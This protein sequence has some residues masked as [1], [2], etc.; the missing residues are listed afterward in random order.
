[1]RKLFAIVHGVESNLRK[2]HPYPIKAPSKN[3]Y[4][5]TYIF[6]Y[7]L[8]VVYL[9]LDWIISGSNNLSNSE[10]LRNDLVDVSY[11]TYAT[12]F[13]GVLTKDKKLMET[14]SRM[15]DALRSMERFSKS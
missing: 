5:N 3:E 9:N 15:R 14:Y 6:R 8:G 10:K 13:D 1:M 12:Y 11:A 7:T 2:K 4:I